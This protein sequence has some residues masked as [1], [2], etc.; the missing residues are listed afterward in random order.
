[1]ILVIFLL[2]L[3]SGVQVYRNFYSEAREEAG[4]VGIHVRHP[5]D[6]RQPFDVLYDL[7]NVSGRNETRS[8]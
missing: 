1:M 4:V 3:N 8:G 6:R 5:S 7:L 2:V